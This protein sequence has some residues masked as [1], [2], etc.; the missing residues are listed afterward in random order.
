LEHL[1]HVKVYSKGDNP[2]PSNQNVD[3]R[4]KKENEYRTMMN[5]EPDVDY[6]KYGYR[7]PEKIASGK[8]TLRQFDELLNEFKKD[9]SQKNFDDLTKKYK[10]MP[11]TLKLL[12]EYYK[13]FNRILNKN[14]KNN[15]DVIENIFPNLIGSTSTDEN[16]K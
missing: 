1:K 3:K 11:E 16:K 10:V 4:P 9:K 14:E 8:L 5:M 2:L 15:S 12:I 6:E 13:P 7:K